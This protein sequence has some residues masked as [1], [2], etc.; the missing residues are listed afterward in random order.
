MAMPERHEMITIDGQDYPSHKEY[1]DKYPHKQYMNKRKNIK[2]LLN[3][4]DRPCADCKLTWHPAVMTLDHVRRDGYKTSK[5]IRRYPSTMLGYPTEM[6]ANELTKCEAVCGNCHKL[7]EMSRDG[8]LNN[9]KWD[10]WSGLPLKG[11]LL[12]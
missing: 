8:H 12:G 4:Y 3:Y 1:F 9:K 5:G 6:Y 10:K 7:R 2:L 11:A